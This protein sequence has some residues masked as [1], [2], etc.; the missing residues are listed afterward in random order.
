MF[1]ILLALIEAKYKTVFG[2]H[3]VLTAFLDFM[4]FIALVEIFGK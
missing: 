2:P 4:F 1:T 3:Y